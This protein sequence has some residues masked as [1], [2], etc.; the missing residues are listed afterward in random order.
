[1]T[2]PKPYFSVIM[3]VHNRANLVG[4]SIRSILRQSF[5]DFELI[6]VNDASTDTTGEV[7]ETFARLDDRVRCRHLAVNTGGAGARNRGVEIARGAR[8]AF[9]DSDDLAFP[10]WLAAAFVKIRALPASWI[11]LYS[12]YY[13]RDGLTGVTYQNVIRPK[14]GWIYEDL[15]RGNHLPVGGSGVIVPR[16]GFVAVGGFDERL[17][18]GH[19]YDLWYRLAERGTFH[20]LNAPVILF[21][22]HR[23]HRISEDAVRK[24]IAAALFRDK[25][26]AEIQRVG[27]SETVGRRTRKHEAEGT[28]A[29]LRKEIVNRGR[30]AGFT[31]LLRSFSID[32]FRPANFLKNLLLLLAGPRLY[33]SFKV[34]RGF[35]YWNIMKRNAGVRCSRG[36]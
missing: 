8:L 28:F 27:G 5:V 29:V 11:V 9:L 3:P 25:W 33:D 22:E 12:R 6:L 1:M 4:R 26:N 23:D 24:P 13:I 31:F 34:V 36:L 2:D 17:F 7:L 15:L 14:E 30:R 32:S 19:D 21:F 35:L 20:F 16:E 10:N 18:A